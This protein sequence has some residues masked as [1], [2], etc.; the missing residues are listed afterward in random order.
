MQARREKV[1]RPRTGTTRGTVPGVAE[2]GQWKTGG[3]VTIGVVFGKFGAGRCTARRHRTV[4]DGDSVKGVVLRPCASDDIKVAAGWTTR[5]VVLIIKISRVQEFETSTDC[6]LGSASSTG[7]IDGN[8]KTAAQGP[9]EQLAELSA[10]T[11]A[12]TDPQPSRQRG[13]QKYRNCSLTVPIELQQ[14]YLH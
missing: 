9:L 8:W 3:I 6:R 5:Q 7:E 12:Y 2:F 13:R 11:N 14:Q 1:V 10:P 4:V